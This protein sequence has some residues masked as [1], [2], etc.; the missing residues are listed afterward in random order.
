MGRKVK[1]PS[2][3]C[4]LVWE[5]NESWTEP[6]HLPAG[7]KDGCGFRTNKAED[8]EPDAIERLSAALSE[9]NVALAAIKRGS[10][11]R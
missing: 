7:H 11:W 4:G 3:V 6:C 1:K 2:G 10:L 8:M 5:G 9:A